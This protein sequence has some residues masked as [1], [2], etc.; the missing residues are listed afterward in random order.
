[1]K[2]LTIDSTM[3]ITK[4]IMSLN[5]DDDYE[6]C[7]KTGNYFEKIKIKWDSDY[8]L[9]IK[10][11]KKVVISN[12]DFAKKRHQDQKEYNTFRTYTMMILGRNVTLENLTI[13]NTCGS[14]KKY[15]QGV[16]LALIGDQ[17]K[18][19]NCRLLGHQDTLF[20]GPLP[21][22]LIERYQNFLPQ[23]ELIFPLPHRIHVKKTYI[24]GDV[25]F[26]FGSAEAYFSECEF[27]SK[28]RHGFVFAPST[29]KN[30]EIGFVVRNCR[31]TSNSK[32]KSSHVYI[33]RPWRDYGYCA[34]Y[35]CQMDN[36]IHDDGFD[37]WNNTSRDKTCRFY[38]FN[39][40]YFDNH[41]YQRVN[42]VKKS[43]M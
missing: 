38:E 22:D 43:D 28:A 8:T 35:D 42:F 1:M 19:N 21:K 10:G 27:N 2:Y 4:T 23:D 24:S 9:T 15:G 5:A 13:E 26:V 37:K 14:G 33:A 29:D 12:N 17:I 7:L 20:L 39:S 40:K 6:I 3:P 31:F 18:L 25:D 41:P 30:D 32:D 16:A 34:L 11:L 36:H